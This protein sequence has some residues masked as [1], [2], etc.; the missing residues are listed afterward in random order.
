MLQNLINHIALIVDKSGSM[1]HQPVVRVFDLELEHLKKRSFEL[2][3]ETRISIYLFDTRVECLTFDMD[4]ARMTS[5]AGYYHA[6][7]QTAL[8]D[9]VLKSTEDHRKLPELYGDHAFLQYVITDGQE[10]ASRATSSQLQH[11]LGNLPNN[12]TT[13]CLVPDIRGKHEAKKFGFS[14][15][16][17]AIWDTTQHN[18]FE[19]VGQQFTRTIDQYMDMRAKG[20]RGTS[21][22]FKMDSSQIRTTDLTEVNPATYTLYKVFVD[23]PIKDYVE[24]MT[25]NPYRVG[26]VYYQPTKRVT[27]Q[28]YKD[29]MVRNTISGKVYAGDNLRSLLG[30][31]DNTVDVDPG[32]HKTWDIF[33]QSTSL[34]RKLI[35]GTSFLVKK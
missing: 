26:S 5:L 18:A 6:D 13:A 14:D 16:S 22:L 10:N 25:G 34:N 17:I 33:V 19:K 35:A 7:G 31:P 3:Q 12:W 20:V 27:I 21:G 8:L 29:V 15:D 28:D 1:V 32:Q 30:L 4:I 11:V 23:G 2:H 24:E 9:A